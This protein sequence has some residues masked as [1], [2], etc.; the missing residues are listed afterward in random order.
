MVNFEMASERIIGGLEKKGRQN[1]KDRLRVAIHESGHAV[2]GWFLEG[3]DPLLKLT[4][5]PRSKGALGFAQYL[6]SES[7]LIMQRQLQDQLVF[8][9][10]GRAAEFLFF[11]DLSTGAHD[12]LQKAYA[13]AYD[14]VTKYA[15]SSLGFKY[16]EDQNI[17]KPYS[18]KT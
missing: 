17:V 13:I 9:F 15:M 2:C 6:P 5:I 4:I 18:S 10:G 1:E 8:I 16:F 7:A 12:D 11:Q 14:M 3:C